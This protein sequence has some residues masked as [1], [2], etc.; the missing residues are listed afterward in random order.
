MSLA[1]EWFA[2]LFHS[3]VFP[4]IRSAFGGKYRTIGVDTGNRS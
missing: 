1:D 3:F 2:G 4:M